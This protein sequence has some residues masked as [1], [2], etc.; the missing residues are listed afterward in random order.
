MRQ[1]VWSGQSQKAS[2]KEKHLKFERE[3]ADENGE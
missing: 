2:L 1:L 3:Q